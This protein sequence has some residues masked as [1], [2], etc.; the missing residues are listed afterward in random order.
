MSYYLRECCRRREA[1]GLGDWGTA[2]HGL[3]RSAC[4]QLSSQALQ[5]SEEGNRVLCDVQPPESR[6]KV[7]REVSSVMACW[8][9]P[10]TKALADEEDF[11]CEQEA[12][13]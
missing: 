6:L 7:L 8:Y 9:V 4:P 10:L 11:G 5:A 3:S 2:G 13:H 12:R 1:E